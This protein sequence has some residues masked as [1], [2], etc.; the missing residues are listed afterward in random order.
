MKST[1]TEIVKTILK[2]KN[3]NFRG[4]VLSGLDLL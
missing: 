1:R 4:I 3:K 2:K